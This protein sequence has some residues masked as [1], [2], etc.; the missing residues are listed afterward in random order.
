MHRPPIWTKIHKPSQIRAVRVPAEVIFS[1]IVVGGYIPVHTHE[2]ARAD[3]IVFLLVL[4]RS[5]LLIYTMSALKYTNLLR[6]VQY[7]CRQR[8]LFPI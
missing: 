2:I 8:L 4:R 6:L 3:Y 7:E 5:G 1:N